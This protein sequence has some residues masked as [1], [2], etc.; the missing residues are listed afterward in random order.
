M[1]GIGQRIGQLIVAMAK[2]GGGTGSAPPP[3]GNQVTANGGADRI[4][5]NAGADTVK[6]NS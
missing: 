1:I 2:I 4:T 6:A 3:G 5:A